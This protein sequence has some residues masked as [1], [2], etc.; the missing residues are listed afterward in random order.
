MGLTAEQ[1][2]F[3]DEAVAGLATDGKVIPVRLSLFAEMTRGKPWTSDNLRALGGAE[4][5][6]VLFL[7]ESLGPRAAR[8]EHRLRQEAARAV[9]RALLPRQGTDI[10]GAMRSRD[11]SGGRGP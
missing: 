9:L 1:G 11:E 6:G 3:L 2:R 5:I 7:E 4:G 10:K 8:P